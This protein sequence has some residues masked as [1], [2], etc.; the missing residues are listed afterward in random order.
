MTAVNFEMIDYLID[1][2]AA[3][4]I[5]ILYK[6]A[7]RLHIG[8][9]AAVVGRI[10]LQIIGKNQQNHRAVAKLVMDFMA[11]AVGILK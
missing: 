9:F 8:V 11:A 1:A 7:R 4:S 5:I 10:M 3:N 6:A 2:K